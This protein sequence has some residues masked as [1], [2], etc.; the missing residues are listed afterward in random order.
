MPEH[1]IVGQFLKRCTSEV[2][3]IPHEQQV[4]KI[5]GVQLLNGVFGDGQ[6]FV[7]GLKCTAFVHG[8]DLDSNSSCVDLSQ[9][10]FD[11]F[12]EK[13]RGIFRAPAVLVTSQVGGG[14]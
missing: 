6:C 11:D 14:V 10:R 3:R 12:E 2:G 8:T 13:A 5:V 4:R 7:V 1:A 9:D